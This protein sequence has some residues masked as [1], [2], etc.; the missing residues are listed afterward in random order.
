[1]FIKLAVILG[2][3]TFSSYIETHIYKD[4]K[5]FR[6]KEDCIEF[7]ENLSQDYRTHEQSPYIQ[8]NKKGD[9]IEIRFKTE[10]GWIWMSA[11]YHLTTNKIE[12]DGNLTFH[13]I[14][15]QLGEI[16][17]N[18][19]VRSMANQYHE[20]IP[21]KY[22]FDAD[23]WK[24]Y[25]KEVLE[26]PDLHAYEKTA[27][28]TTKKY[29]WFDIQLLVTT[30]E[31]GQKHLYIFEQSTLVIEADYDQIEKRIIVTNQTLHNHLFFILQEEIAT[32]LEE[33][34]RREN[35]GE[36]QA[37]LENQL[38]KEIETI[39]LIPKF[40]SIVQETNE[41]WTYYQ[42]AKGKDLQDYI[43]MKKSIE[44][45]KGQA[46]KVQKVDEKQKEVLEETIDEN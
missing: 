30:D 28:F 24:C 23:R 21:K 36:T 14:K 1:M 16:E 11:Y 8:L 25:M 6:R 7:L 34:I 10:K 26:K 13:P 31:K 38:R 39:P 2:L 22:Q 42:Q 29:Q 45:L 5:R 40:R 20:Q 4:I 19:W 37:R 41:L 18:R 15:Q 43:T 46:R 44:F 9:I 32:F 33:V 17:M 12:Y 35:N 27:L 3:V